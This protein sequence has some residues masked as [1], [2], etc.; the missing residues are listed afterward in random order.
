MGLMKKAVRRA[1]PRSVRKAKRVAFHPARTAVHAATPRSIRKVKRTAFNVTHPVNTAE[2]ALLDSLTGGSRR[3]SRRGGGS[4]STTSSSSGAYSTA[5]EERLRIGE[6]IEEVETANFSV[7]PAPVAV[8]TRPIA[9]PIAAPDVARERE[10]I[11]GR[12]GATELAAKL[13]PFG[14]PPAAP[15]PE[16]VSVKAIRRELYPL[17]TSGIP[18]W[19]LKERHERR[20]QARERAVEDAKRQTERRADTQTREQEDLNADWNKLEHLR[21]AAESE[22]RQWLVEET[23]RR[24]A[25]RE[26]QQVELDAQWHRLLANDPETVATALRRALGETPVVV[27]GMIVGTPTALLAVVV[28][29][30]DQAIAD[31]EAGYTPTGRPTLRTRSKTRMNELYLAAIASRILFAAEVAVAAAPGLDGVRCVALRVDDSGAPEPVYAGTVQSQLLQTVK[32]SAWSSDPD[33]LTQIPAMALDVK[34]AQRGRAH[35]LSALARDV[36]G[37]VET[38]MGL[39]DAGAIA[40]PPGASTQWATHE[41]VATTDRDRWPVVGAGRAGHLCRRCARK[42]LEAGSGSGGSAR[43][44][45]RAVHGPGDRLRDPRSSETGPRQPQRTG[46][47]G[48]GQRARLVRQTP[49]EP[50]VARA[51]Q[52]GM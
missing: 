45:R 5:T 34:I 9:P 25:T 24:Q 36:D 30:Q 33:V 52:G 3:S 49:P 40:S 11:E 18:R 10:R 42:T 32:D 23:A 37:S 20:A 27:V 16:P 48:G 6:T 44:S 43:D 19:K 21:Q 41:P 7:H 17:A 14:S 22:A 51:S 2:N 1:T 31:R 8:A 4:Y 26:R 47:L 15:S 50:P 39:Y 28:P 13:E 29:Q 46:A 35:E 38:V 12:S